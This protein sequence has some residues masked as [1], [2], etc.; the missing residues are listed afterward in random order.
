M[1]TA[2][3]TRPPFTYYIFFLSFQFNSRKTT[4]CPLMLKAIDF[5]WL[6][7][8][9]VSFACLFLMLLSCCYFF[10]FFYSCITTTT[11]TT[12]IISN[13][14]NEGE[15]TPE[16]SYKLWSYEFWIFGRRKERAAPKLV[17]LPTLGLGSTYTHTHKVWLQYKICTRWCNPTYT[18]F[19]CT[20]VLILA[21]GLCTLV[22]FWAWS[23]VVSCPCSNS[24]RRRRE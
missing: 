5:S 19:P 15:G 17:L 20:W 22:C 21:F 18:C 6:W 23:H 10:F 8:S 7:V 12:T 9:W 24:E 14:I 2:T 3:I 11:T 4:L 13:N 1:L 16:T